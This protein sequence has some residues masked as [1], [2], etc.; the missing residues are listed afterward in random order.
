MER[1]PIGLLERSRRC[2]QTVAA[3]LP[4]AFLFLTL[5]SG[6]AF[7]QGAAHPSSE[8]VLSSGYK[9]VQTTGRD[10]FANICQGCHM[11]DA[12]GASGAGMY[13]SIANNKKLE[14]SGYPVYIVVNGQR[15]MPPFGAMLSDDQVS[16]V[17]NYLRTN[18]GNDYRDAVTAA[19]VKAVRP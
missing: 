16:A 11:P 12:N 10:L 5:C 4:G 19:D 14:A 3:T 2:T 1:I 17:V 6:G 15:A 7:A 18:F 13:P 9:F 8:P